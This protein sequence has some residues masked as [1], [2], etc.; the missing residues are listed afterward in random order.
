MG[1]SENAIFTI[2]RDYCHL[3]PLTWQFYEGSVHSPF[4]TCPWDAC[5][6]PGRRFS[7]RWGGSLLNLGGNLTSL[8]NMNSQSSGKESWI[9]GV[10]T[11]F[12]G[13]PNR[14]FR[15]LAPGWFCWDGDEL[16]DVNSRTGSTK[17]ENMASNRPCRYAQQH[18]AGLMSMG[19]GMA[20]NHGDEADAIWSN[21]MQWQW[22][23]TIWRTHII[24]ISDLI[25]Y[26]PQRWVLF[27]YQ[28]ATNASLQFRTCLFWCWAILARRVRDVEL[29]V[30][31]TN[32]TQKVAGPVSSGDPLLGFW[33]R[34]LH[35]AW[36]QCYPYHCALHWL[37]SNA[38]QIW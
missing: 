30:Q 23:N 12:F 35:L 1:L 31:P 25:R 4:S 28:G 36:V 5:Q 33:V 11:D 3:F 26:F 27:K 37:Q 21:D 9:M 34:T 15:H 24:I 7:L 16:Q 22:T 6:V 32:F 38:H 8:I 18:Y 29:S 19:V 20:S 13:V 14:S 10:W 2:R 17:L